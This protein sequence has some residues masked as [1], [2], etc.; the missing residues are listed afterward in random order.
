[1][2][3]EFTEWQ[4]SESLYIIDH[5]FI[6]IWSQFVIILNAIWKSYLKQVLKSMNVI[7]V[8]TRIIFFFVFLVSLSNIVRWN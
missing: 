7:L 4:C 1:M 8:L 6:K 3:S 2:F 5:G